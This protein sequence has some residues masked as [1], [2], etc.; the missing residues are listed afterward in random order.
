MNPWSSMLDWRFPRETGMFRPSA[1]EEQGTLSGTPHVD[2]VE[3]PALTLGTF[4]S[5]S[6][7]TERNFFLPLFRMNQTP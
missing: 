6:I 2:M 3:G 4:M 1:M 5:F 7:N